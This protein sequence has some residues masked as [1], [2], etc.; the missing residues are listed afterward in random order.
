[1]VVEEKHYFPR[2]A[3]ENS[4]VM[5]RGV[6]NDSRVYRVRKPKEITFKTERTNILKTLD[7][8]D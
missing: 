7:C 4:L 3:G 2:S 8:F 5:G 6:G 1:M